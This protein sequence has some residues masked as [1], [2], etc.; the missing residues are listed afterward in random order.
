[1]II[2]KFI[3]KIVIIHARN[4]IFVLKIKAPP[5]TPPHKGGE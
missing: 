2:K 4:I 3:A 5:P 1:M